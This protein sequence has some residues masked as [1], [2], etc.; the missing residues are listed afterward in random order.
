MIAHLS[1]TIAEKFATSV[2]LD[3]H[4]VGYEVTLT[5]LDYGRL[6]VGDSHKFYTH[7]AVREV[8]EE[9]FGFSS[10]AAKRLFELLISVNGVGPRAAMAIMSLASPEEI[11]SA[12]ASAD[13]AF[14]AK[15]NGVGKKSA[16]RVV[17]D[18]QDKVGAPSHYN[19]SQPSTNTAPDDALDALMAL[20]YNL[21]EATTALAKIDPTLPT[22][23]RIRAAIK[24][25]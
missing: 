7:H 10:L 19:V 22:E 8:S 18:L 2:I 16:E 5:Q 25:F 14:I 17:V 15:A 3:V 1:G 21:K 12:I 23:A 4:G 6:A 11:R 20:G 24:G 9:L 13:T